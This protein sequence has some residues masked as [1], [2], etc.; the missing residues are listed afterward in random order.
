MNDPKINIC[1]SIWMLTYDCI[2]LT[3]MQVD[4]NILCHVRS[5]KY[6][7]IGFKN[8]INNRSQISVPNRVVVFLNRTMGTG[9]NA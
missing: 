1:A 7:T 9:S 6:G 5:L 4:Q 3:I 2:G 8:P